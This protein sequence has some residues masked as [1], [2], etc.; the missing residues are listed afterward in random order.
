MSSPRKT[1]E[2]GV[3]GCRVV[4]LLKIPDL[5]GNLT[6]CQWK[7]QWPFQPRRVFF[8]H[9]VP[10]TTVRGQHA[11]KECQQLL[12]CVTGSIRVVTDDGNKRYEFLLKDNGQALYIPAGIWATQTYES[13]NSVLVVFAS[14][15]Y[16]EADYLR[17]YEEFLE[18]RRKL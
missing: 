18:F 2:T 17:N 5:R 6:I 16:E 10:S 14:H 11:H 4:D 12:A 8:V 15:E 9:D 1:E 13:P 7:D 3:H